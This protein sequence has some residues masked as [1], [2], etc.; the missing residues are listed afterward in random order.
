LTQ[1][2]EAIPDIPDFAMAAIYRAMSKEPAERFATCSEFA[3]ALSKP[4]VKAVSFRKRGVLPA[5][6]GTIL[7]AALIIGGAIIIAGKDSSSNSSNNSSNSSSS[8]SSSVADSQSRAADSEKDPVKTFTLPNNVK[9]EMVLVEPGSFTMSKRDG[10]NERDEIEHTKTLTKPFY[11]GK[12]EVTQAQWKSLMG[13]DVHQQKDKGN[14]WGRVTGVGDN[15]PMY[16]VSWREAMEFC[17]KMNKY[18][19]PGWQFTLPT[20]TQWEYAARG[21]KKSRG[22]KYS[23]SDNLGDVDWYWGNS[24]STTHEVGG[25]SANELGLYDMSGNVYEYCLDNYQDDSRKTT[26]EF[27]RAYRDSD[28]SFRVFRGGGWVSVA[29]HCRSA[30]RSSFD[31]VIRNSHLGFRLAL[32]QAE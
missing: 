28:G 19:P 21:G 24:G 9:L 23:G 14:S 11:I 16:F 29:R 32:V 30:D 12:Y 1:T 22:Y 2:A 26:A 13:T 5:L 27:T 3:A 10:N 17:E 25:K 20:E 8:S 31:P 7:G 6:M 4:Q 18:A 15:H